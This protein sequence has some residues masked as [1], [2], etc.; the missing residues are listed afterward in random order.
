MDHCT[1]LPIRSSVWVVKLFVMQTNAVDS[2]A[3]K[4]QS[5][6]AS[7]GFQKLGSSLGFLV[8]RSSMIVIVPSGYNVVDKSVDK[9]AACLKPWCFV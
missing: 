4:R 5:V 3:L 2:G 9:C 7:M 1:S 8:K 6:S